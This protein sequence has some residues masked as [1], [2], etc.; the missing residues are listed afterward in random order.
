M[1][2]KKTFTLATKIK[3]YLHNFLLTQSAVTIIAL[4]ITTAWGLAFSIASPLGNLI[5]AP[6][7]TIFLLISSLLFFTTLFE[8]PNNLLYTGFDLIANFWYWLLHL[9]TKKWLIGFIN[10]PFWLLCLFCFF[11]Y[12][13]VSRT[14]RLRKFSPLTI[15]AAAL[16]LELFFFWGYTKYAKPKQ[17]TVTEL[18]NNKGKLV[19]L[20][21]PNNTLSLY[22]YGYFKGKLNPDKT[23][24][25]ELRPYLLKTFGTTK[26]RNLHFLA[27]SR[28]NFIAADAFALITSVGKIHIPYFKK[29]LQK[30]GWHA[31]FNCKRRLEQEHCQWIRFQKPPLKIT[32]ATLNQYH[33]TSEF[34]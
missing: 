13:I 17:T 32:E 20:A 12:Q 14:A 4:P 34:R 16:I 18:I 5:F 22:D 24:T 30:S 2:Q 6:L 33:K 23:I 25:Y 27:A 19:I 9:G 26:I 7:L 21:H 15:L 11:L 28:A 31:F 8:I 3:R 29:A 10:P 1:N